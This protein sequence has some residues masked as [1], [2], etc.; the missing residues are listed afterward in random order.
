M[1]MIPS[2]AGGTFVKV[3]REAYL[4]RQ[5]SVCREIDKI[6]SLAIGLPEALCKNRADSL[7]YQDDCPP[8]EP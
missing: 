3:L 5:L 7:F 8:A 6:R 1:T 2:P 4:L